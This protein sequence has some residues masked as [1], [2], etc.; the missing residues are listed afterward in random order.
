MNVHPYEW[1]KREMSEALIVAGFRQ[2]EEQL[3]P[4]H[5]GSAFIV[6]ENQRWELRLVWDGKE[7][8]GVIQRRLAKSEVDWADI[9]EVLTEGDLEGA[10]I[11]RTKVERWR[12]SIAELRA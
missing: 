10:V 9:A 7:G 1:L 4:D 5:F 6:F 11:E 8:Y 12:D 3:H 2:R